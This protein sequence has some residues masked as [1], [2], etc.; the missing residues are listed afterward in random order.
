MSRHDV[1]VIDGRAYDWPRLCDLRRAQM[2]ARRA[3]GGSSRCSS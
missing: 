1:I 2:E 3:A